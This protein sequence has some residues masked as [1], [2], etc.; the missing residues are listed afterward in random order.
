MSP[1]SLVRL[2]VENTQERSLGVEY[3]GRFPYHPLQD[4][5]EGLAGMHQ[6][7]D[8]PECMVEGL[9]ICFAGHN[10][11]LCTKVAVADALMITDITT[12]NQRIV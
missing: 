9:V 3:F 6:F 5:P 10:N 2:W 1:N 4:L 11:I 12:G 8:V 7:A